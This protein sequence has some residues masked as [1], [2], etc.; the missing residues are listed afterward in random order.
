M[1]HKVIQIVVVV[2]FDIVEDLTWHE[3]VY[4][5]T[6]TKQT[7]GNLVF[8]WGSRHIAVIDVP[9]DLCPLDR[10]TRIVIEKSDSRHQGC[11]ILLALLVYRKSNSH[12]PSFT[13]KKDPRINIIHGRTNGIHRSNIM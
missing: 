12:I 4:K 13:I 10:V 2:R 7:L 3:V 8:Q 9:I 11:I 5:T 6:A 1:M